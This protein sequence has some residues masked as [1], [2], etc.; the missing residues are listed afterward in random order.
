MR[1]FIRLAYKGTNY[2]GWQRQ[3]NAMTIQQ[4]IE[5][6]FTMLLGYE[7][8]LFGCGR[9]DAGV[10]ASDYVAH[11]D[12]GEIKEG[13]DVKFKVNSIL[14]YDI[15]IKELFPVVEEFH[16]R[17]DA[18]SRTYHYYINRHHNPF[19]QELA[20][21]TIYK[22]ELDKLNEI[23]TLISRYN[24]FKPFCKVGSDNTGYLCDITKSSWTIEEFNGFEYF[25]YTITA[26]RFL[27]GMIRLIVGAHIN[28]ARGKY[29]IDDLIHC[30]D[31]QSKLPIAWSVPGDGLY[32]TD[33]CYDLE[34]I[35][36]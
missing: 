3:P 31:E 23:A 24:S 20:L 8:V 34:S 35:R 27:R 33:I 28:I 13:L 10:H 17:F 30:M 19:S 7:V 18:T 36:K 12:L 2:H 6:A 4:K 11:C 22:F 21:S 5:E 9:T 25:K 15:V 14:P 29:S 16:A 1:Y 26:N 32:L